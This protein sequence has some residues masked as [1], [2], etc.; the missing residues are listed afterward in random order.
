MYDHLS[1]LN[2]IIGL[3]AKNK[4]DAVADVAESRMGKSSMGKHRATDMGP[5]RFM[6]P[7]MR[8]IST[9]RVREFKCKILRY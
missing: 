8:N 2:E 4:I 6:P 9:H 1:A 5:G 3:L 7:E